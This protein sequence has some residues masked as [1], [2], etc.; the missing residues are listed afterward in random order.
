MKNKISFLFQ[1]ETTPTRSFEVQTD[2]VRLPDVPVKIRK[3]SRILYPTGTRSLDTSGLSPAL[4]KFSAPP[5]FPAPA[6]RRSVAVPQTGA[7]DSSVSSIM[8]LPP[9]L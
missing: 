7:R 5:A 2:P 4:R 6:P 3:S 8:N 9:F 1:A